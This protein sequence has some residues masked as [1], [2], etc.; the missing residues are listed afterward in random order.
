MNYE[1]RPLC[2]AEILDSANSEQLLAEYA[3]ECSI[4]EIG[5]PNPQK[6]LYAQMESSGLMKCFGVFGDGVLIGFAAML[7]FVVPHYGKKVASVESL[8]VEQE[9]RSSGM[10]IALMR[11]I[12]EEAKASECVA[13]LYSAPTGSQL[14]RLLSLSKSCRRTNSVFTNRLQ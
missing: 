7:F 2:Y 9:H 6:E 10:G 4:P 13:V 8:F 3:A 14:E 5:V 11:T 12:E 1:I